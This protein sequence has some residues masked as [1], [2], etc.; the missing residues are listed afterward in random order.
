MSKHHH[1]RR[2]FLGQFTSGCASLGITTLLSGWSNMALLNAAANCNLNFSSNTEYRGLVCILLNGGNDSYNML[3]PR[4]QSE[5]SEYASIRTNLSIPQQDILPINPLNTVDRSLGLHPNL[6]GLQNLFASEKLSFIANAGS[7]IEPTDITGFNNN[8][9]LPLGLFS[10]SDQQQH[11]Q[12]SVPQDRNSLGWAGR[13]TDLI[14]GSTANE[15]IGLNVSLSGLNFFQRGNFVETATMSSFGNGATVI[16]NSNSSTFTQQLKRQ[17][18]D[19][20][21][22]QTYTNVLDKAYASSVVGSKNNS[23][24]L[25]S[26]IGSIGD[27]NTTFP[28]TPFGNRMRMVARTIAAREAL[29]LQRQTFYISM[30]GFDTHNDI[31]SEHGD[32][33]TELDAVLTAFHTVLDQ[34]LSIAVQVTTFT[35]SDFSRKL[36]SNGDGSDH[37]WGGNS[38]I[39]GG[40]IKG[41]HIFGQYPD[42]F[43]GN[44]LDVGQGRIIPTTS[45]DE[46]FA[47]LALWFGASS[48]DLNTVLP[49]LQNFWDY[50]SATL[51]LGLYQ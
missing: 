46:F 17:T 28:D 37:A 18:I 14:Y 25:D 49:N 6:S 42:L 51:P 31:L 9:N 41:G 34:E 27:F 39:M 24:I 50:R 4:G 26:A 23:I 20:I 19:N 48:S 15:K 21:L 22:D 13:L 10:H 33:L 3:I 8:T 45:C 16:N 43:E 12:T 29:G 35:I 5:Y 1:T 7:L 36:I 30:N 44:S 40:G 2:Q 11:W 47:E 38:I 32:L